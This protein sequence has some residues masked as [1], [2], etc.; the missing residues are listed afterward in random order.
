MASQRT[1][2]RRFFEEEPVKGSDHEPS[3]SNDSSDSSDSE[4]SS[5][6]GFIVS[7]SEI[8]ED[9]SSQPLDDLAF[10]RARVEAAL[11]EAHKLRRE[12]DTLKRQLSDTHKERRKWKRRAIQWRNIAKYNHTQK[13]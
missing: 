10:E 11:Q 2:V 13:P 9:Q 3:D 12:I 4:Y 7:D 5:D 1:Y 6:D 8:Q